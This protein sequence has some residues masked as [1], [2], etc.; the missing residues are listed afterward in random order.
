MPS[1]QRL[2]S[3]TSALIALLLPLGVSACGSSEAS[4]GAGKTPAP[5]ST[6]DAAGKGVLTYKETEFA[7]APAKQKAQAGE[8]TFKVENAG[9]IKHEF[10][11]IKTA[12]PA[13]ALDKG[14]EAD[15]TG[16]VDEIGDIEPGATQSL[17]VK[18]EPGH[19][20]LVCNL[21]GHYK[22]GGKDGMLADVTVR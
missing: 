13:D 2:R 18:L 3:A 7:I 8:V 14:D 21:P 20:A 4:T 1:H 17:K 16:A 15:E 6:A 10:V 19:Y 5:E 22:P 11:V 9:E 12:K